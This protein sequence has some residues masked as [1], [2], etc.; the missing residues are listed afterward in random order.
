MTGS[1]KINIQEPGKIEMEFHMNGMNGFDRFILLDALAEV[2]EFNEMDRVFYSM[3]FVKGGMKA[4]SN[5]DITK[6][7]MSSELVKFFKDKEKEQ[8]QETE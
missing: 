7:E 6:A 4:M 8:H 2:M 5:V 3:M 1:I